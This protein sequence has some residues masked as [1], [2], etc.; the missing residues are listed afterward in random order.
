MHTSPDSG[1]FWLSEPQEFRKDLLCGRDKVPGI[2][3]CN[4]ER[5]AMA[6]D[7]TPKRVKAGAGRP[8]AMRCKACAGRFEVAHP[9]A[10]ATCPDCGEGW[11]IRWFTPDS[12]MIIA[13]LNWTDYQVRSRGSAAGGRGNA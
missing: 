7:Y 10:T 3:F 12:G 2:R 13:P 6:R 8:V 11:K 4:R 1:G 9:A 5:V